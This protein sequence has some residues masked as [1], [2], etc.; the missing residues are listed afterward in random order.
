MGDLT[1][2]PYHRD[3]AAALTELLN[4]IGRIDGGHGGFEPGYIGSLV[5][6][7]V[8]DPAADTRLVFDGEGSLVAASLVP[9]PPPGGFR[10]DLMGGV[11]PQWRGQGIGRDLFGWTMRRA[12]QL[13]GQVA[14]TD[15]WQVEAYL[16]EDE[17]TFRQL[18]IRCG[19]TLA[20]YFFD[21]GA[22]TAGVEPAPLPAGLRAEPFPTDRSREV[23]DAHVEAF[24]DHWG[25]QRHRFEDW[26]ALTVESDVFRADLS[27]VAY[28]G[29][30]IAGY[31]LAY[32]EAMPDRLYLGQVGTRRPW[33]RRGLAGA[34]LTHVLSAACAAGRKHVALEVDADSPTG[35]V[36]VYERA[37]FVVEARG[38]AY[39]RRLAPV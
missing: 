17:K 20:R 35:A 9:V 12:A 28:D 39:R 32:E 6:T 34:L 8:A 13:H 3:D 21:M 2:R 25:Y 14:P 5:R 22:P 31:I 23:Y 26:A 7:T 29:A 4:E 24:N 16:V 38:A 15:E 33:R 1:S 11:R 37:G 30:E 19:F 10:L 18:L 36:G 27:R